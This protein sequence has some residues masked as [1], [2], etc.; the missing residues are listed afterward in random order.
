MATR[1]QPGARPRI[2][3]RNRC[4]IHRSARPI[5]AALLV[6]LLLPDPAQTAET[7][8]TGPGFA[9]ASRIRDPTGDVRKLPSDGSDRF[10]IA[11]VD[12]ALLSRY[13][14]SYEIAPDRIVVLGPLDELDRI[15]LYVDLKTL[16][17]GALHTHSATELFAGPTVL[18]ALPAAFELTF[19][20][21]DRD[22]VDGAWWTEAGGASVFA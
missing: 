14:G 1:I 12:P 13:T 4:S 19:E 2:P 8:A 18:G 21:N 6:A 22:E 5:G 3:D 9:V 17:T 16:R 10:S 11:A 20:P 15:L 7:T